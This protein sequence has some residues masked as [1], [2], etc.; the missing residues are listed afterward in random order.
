M[1]RP[2]RRCGTLAVLENNLAVETVEM[3]HYG[4]FEGE[5]DVNPVKALH[6]GTIKWQVPLGLSPYGGFIKGVPIWV[7]RSSLAAASS[8]SRPLWTITFETSM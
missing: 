5:C 7:V 4:I 1:S 3:E 8:L 6:Q 2:R